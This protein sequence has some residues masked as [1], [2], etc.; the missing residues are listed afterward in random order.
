[1]EESRELLVEDRE[2]ENVPSSGR[3]RQ[4]GAASSIHLE[5]QGQYG[6]ACLINNSGAGR[7]QRQNGE[8]V[9]SRSGGGGGGAFGTDAVSQQVSASSEVCE[10]KVTAKGAG[11]TGRNPCNQ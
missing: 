6:N 1:M 3:T 8:T 7:N 10:E 2:K 9:S 5:K 4:L 11:A